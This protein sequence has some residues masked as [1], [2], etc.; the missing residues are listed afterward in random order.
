METTR[1]TPIV[2]HHIDHSKYPI[3]FSFISN[4][5]K[6]E[7]SE[8][9]FCNDP[10]KQKDDPSSCSAISIDNSEE[11]EFIDDENEES[12]NTVTDDD[13]AITK[14]VGGNTGKRRGVATKER[15]KSIGT[16]RR[17]LLDLQMKA[18]T[19][20]K[21]HWLSHKQR[22]W[23]DYFQDLLAWKEQ[24]NTFSIPRIP[25][26]KFILARWAVK[27]R[28][29]YK[30]RT[31][32]RRVKGGIITQE[33]IDK[34]NAIGFP[35]TLGGNNK[36]NGLKSND[37]GIWNMRFNQLKN[38]CKSYG[39]CNV[40]VNWEENTALSHWVV[41]MRRKHIAMLNGKGQKSLT[42]E[43]VYMLN[44]I[45]F[46]W[47]PQPKEY[48]WL[49]RFNHVKV[50]HSK[51]GHCD[52]PPDYYLDT[53]LCFWVRSQRWLK[54]EGGLSKKRVTMLETLGFKWEEDDAD[55]NRIEEAV[56]KSSGSL[57]RFAITK[58]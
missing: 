50:F 30:M 22:P 52:V 10:G 42:E 43:R 3:K 35:W 54:L 5:E 38:Y 51:H 46:V 36:D 34:L 28:L 41:N 13:G 12:D 48:T 20:D 24:F 39:T 44:Q 9:E 8:K 15:L 7:G 21:S 29:F 16:E 14:E 6:E 1:T 25:G 37:P 31:D 57:Q 4:D 49:E 53:N 45:N 47:R 11:V 58:L 33:R 27:Q 55:K 40:P 18:M 56:K 2:I 23:E 17:F 26:G 19:G 32:G